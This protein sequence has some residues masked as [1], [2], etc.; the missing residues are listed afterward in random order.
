MSKEVLKDV[1]SVMYD[2]APLKSFVISVLLGG[3]HE[4]GFTLSG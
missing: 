4:V 2:V 3:L 1:S